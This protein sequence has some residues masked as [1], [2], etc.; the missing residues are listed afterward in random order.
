MSKGKQGKHSRKGHAKS[1]GGAG[2]GGAAERKRGAKDRDCA[3]ELKRGRGVKLER[4]LA[5]KCCHPARRTC[6]NCPL[7]GL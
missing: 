4:K 2:C 7:K 3:T 5:E 1:K 6:K